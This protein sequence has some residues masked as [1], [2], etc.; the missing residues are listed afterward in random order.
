MGF[1]LTEIEKQQATENHNLVFHFLSK[2]HLNV[3][4]YYDVVVFGYFK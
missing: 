1:Q 4:E 3:D 2:H